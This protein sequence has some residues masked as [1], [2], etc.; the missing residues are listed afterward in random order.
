MS[1]APEETKTALN[2]SLDQLA[3]A[4]EIRLGVSVWMDGWE[5]EIGHNQ[6]QRFPL[7]SVAKLL[8]AAVTL[9]MQQQGG[10]SPQIDLREPVY[11][12]V[13]LHDREASTWLSTQAGGVAQINRMLAQAGLHSLHVTDHHAEPENSGTPRDLTRLLRQ[14]TARTFPEGEAADLVLRALENQ[15]DP[16][17][18]RSG[19]P[20]ECAWA[21]M[22]GGL[23]D[24]CNDVGIIRWDGGSALLSVMAQGALP[25][26]RLERLVGEVGRLTYHLCAQ[27]KPRM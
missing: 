14:L 18:V 1:R 9:Q 20:P 24:V 19:I 15:A 3:I 25:W 13:S 26:E 11:R 8:I 5:Q 2:N 10:V 22:T 7:A 12:A 17:G 4:S 16:D 6:E 23:T 21:H 27:H